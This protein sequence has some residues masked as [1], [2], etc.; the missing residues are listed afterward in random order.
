MCR[1]KIIIGLGKALV[2]LHG[3]H[4]G[5][6]YVVHGDIKPSNIMLDEELNA[7]LGDFGLARLVDHGAAPP[8]TNIAMGTR[9]YVEP[10]F[11]ETHKRCKE[12]D[13]YSFGIVLLEMVTG[14]GPVSQPLRHRVWE[15]YG[16]G[17]ILEAASAA[18]RSESNDRQ[19]ER[20]LVVG[21][22]CTQ[23]AR[24]Q[25]PPIER[26]MGALE[27]AS[28]DAVLPPDL[29]LMLAG[30]H[31]SEPPEQR[32]QIHG[33]L[34]LVSSH[35]SN[36]VPATA[37]AG[38]QA[39]GGSSSAVT[40]AMTSSSVHPSSATHSTNYTTCTLGAPGASMPSL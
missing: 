26:A 12:S 39:Y 37:T 27:H 31:M 10:E 7:K 28:A 21:L 5:T 29:P 40:A 33:D 23:E 15:L 20:V 30:A 11:M 36:T 1:Y 16:Q 4:S 6:K 2:Y 14:H 19:M 25:R 35:Y 22:W 3:E 38:E 18:L 13:V 8:T 17:K 9:G 34:A 24:S 32:L